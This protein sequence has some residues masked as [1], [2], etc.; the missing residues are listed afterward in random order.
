[1]QCVKTVSCLF[2]FHGIPLELFK[3]AKGL[4][5]GDPLSLYLFAIGMEYLSMMLN[6]L[7]KD[8]RFHFHPR[9]RIINMF[10]DDLLLFCKVDESF[11][12]RLKEVFGKFSRTL[13]LTANNSKS[14]AYFEGLHDID[15]PPLL[16]ILEGNHPFR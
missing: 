1:M 8:P 6:T 3:A 9:F 5:Q 10:A 7:S 13:G 15:K 4:R 11:I 12:L 16:Q 2:L 14:C